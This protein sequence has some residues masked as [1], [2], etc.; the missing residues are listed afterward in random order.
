MANALS[1][2]EKTIEKVL[3][4]DFQFAIP[5][6]QRPYRWGTDEALQLLDDLE[7]CL[8]RSSDE[9]YFLGSLVLVEAGGIEFDVI[10]GQQR[11]TTLT[12]LFAV[13]RDLA[14]PDVAGELDQYVRE[15][16][17]RVAGRMPKPRLAL[18]TQDR[19]FFEAR[20]QTPGGTA[21]IGD[22]SDTDAAT[23]PQRAIRDNASALRKRLESTTD[24]WRLELAQFVTQST[25]LVVVAAPDLNSAYR[26]FSVMN[27]RGL[28]LTPA[29]IFKSQVTGELGDDATET[30]RW[31][32]LE[33]SLGTDDFSDLF[34]DI[35][36]V[37]SGDRARREL[38]KEFPE[39]VLGSYLARGADG[40]RDFVN[41]VL[42]PYGKAFL[43]LRERDFAGEGWHE[44]NV[45]LRRLAALDN[46]DWRPSALWV[47]R[48]HASD[49]V[50]VATFLAKLERVAA[51][52][53]LTG[54]YTTPRTMRF[55]ELLNQLR[56]GDELDATALELS[57][58]E[59]ADALNALEGE[60]Y[61]MQ[62]RRARY[63]LLRLDEVLAQDPGVSYSHGVLSIEHV[64]PQ[65][66]R[67][68]SVW[69]ANFTDEQR[70]Y[71]VHRLGNLVLLNRKK[72]SQAGN[73]DFDE[74][75]VKYFAASGG[76]AVFALTTQVLSE[77]VWT[78]EVIGRRQEAL[79]RTLAA[80]WGLLD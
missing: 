2:H 78:P 14:S 64:L 53:L 68:E 25:Y 36:T 21:G 10:D 61:R 41:S 15:P 34:R 35:R 19:E 20:I 4:S 55:L 59:R 24:E 40:R 26:I 13:L 23:E 32:G 73:Y 49:P 58:E 1:A 39:Q 28:D 66:P 48:H 43:H 38:L 71:W 3:C 30:K 69:M 29:D 72:N 11:L 57:A 16:G 65:R 8:A 50:Y 77:P 54:K 56:D 18:R 47:L 33:E 46:F 6:Y 27:A 70:D 12:I 75:K 51:Y 31:E 62:S 79:V 17:S 80:T 45:W 7:E 76:S 60:V 22:L 63:V 37:I 5:G 44:V 42:D 52:L 67:E 9:P 74:K